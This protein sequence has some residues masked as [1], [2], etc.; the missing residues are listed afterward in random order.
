LEKPPAT[1]CGLQFISMLDVND[2]AFEEIYVAAFEVLDRIWLEKK[3]SYM[4]FPIVLHD[5]ISLV[6]AALLQSPG[7]VERLR[8]ILL[9]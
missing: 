1:K 6:K 9:L 4:Q 5:T 7:S 8:E 3:A 2:R